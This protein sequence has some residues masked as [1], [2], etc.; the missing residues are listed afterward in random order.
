MKQNAVSAITSS[1]KLRKDRGKDRKTRILVVDDDGDLLRLMSYRL[2]AAG[3][4]IDCAESGE[5]ALG[6][7][8]AAQ[9]DLVI[10]DLQM[11]GISGMELFDAIHDNYPGL[12]VIILT[13]HGTIPDAVN[14][15]RNGVAS[16]LTKPFDSQ[17]LLENIDSALRMSGSSGLPGSTAN[18]SWRQ[19]IISP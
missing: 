19:N 5:Q 12:P 6:I 4:N 18:R 16:F 3:F 14:A 11:G 1:I 7:I 8:S 13:A 10:T 15:T 9:P 2:K 17:A